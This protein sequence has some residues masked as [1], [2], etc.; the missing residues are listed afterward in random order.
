MEIISQDE[1]YLEIAGK[2]YKSRLIIGSG[3]FKNF[4]ENLHSLEASGSEIITVAIRRELIY[5]I[6]MKL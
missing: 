5:Q 6:Q 3:K 4:E 1:Q 2:E